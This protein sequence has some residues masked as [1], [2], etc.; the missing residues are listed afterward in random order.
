MTN[1]YD[2]TADSAGTITIPT[3][4]VTGTPPA[5]PSAL[6]KVKAQLATK[7]A[8]LPTWVWG[9]AALAVLGMAMTPSRKN[10]K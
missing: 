9:G 4:T 5:S 2:P 8:G 1:A 6:T 3:V 10:R 7:R